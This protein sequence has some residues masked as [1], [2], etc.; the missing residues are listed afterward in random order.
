M[1]RFTKIVCTLGPSSSD[2][3]TLMQ[4]ID[5]GMNVARLNFSHGTHESHLEML[6]LVRQCSRES[7]KPVA[8]LQDLQGPKLRVGVLP[9]EGIVLKQGAVLNLYTV[10]HGK[11]DFEGNLLSLPLDVP[12]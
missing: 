4:L 8:I 6:N 2:K 12:W 10:G 3:A 1:F 7:G 5:A 9:V 11:E